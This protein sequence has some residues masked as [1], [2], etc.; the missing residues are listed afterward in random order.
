MPCGP[1]LSAD[2]RESCF[3]GFW[4]VAPQLMPY[5]L[6]STREA[7]LNR[8]V[9]PGPMTGQ[10]VRWEVLTSAG[11]CPQ[12]LSERQVVLPLRHDWELGLTF[13]TATEDPAQLCFGCGGSRAFP[14]LENFRGPE[15][16]SLWI[17]WGAIQSVTQLSISPPACC[18]TSALL[19][20][21]TAEP[22]P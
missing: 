10:M 6:G 11:D 1:A 3:A 7:G 15:R 19:L 22:T 13:R 12:V 9:G 5:P 18:L 16:D 4:Q 17:L 14:L 8:D 21:G 2:A 20:T